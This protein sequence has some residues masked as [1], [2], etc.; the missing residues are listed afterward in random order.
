[1]DKMHCIM[2]L[3]M[4]KCKKTIIMWLVGNPTIFQSHW[5]SLVQLN[6]IRAVQGHCEMVYLHT[7]KGSTINFHITWTMHKSYVTLQWLHNERDGV[8]NHQRLYCLLKCWL[9]HKSKKTIWKLH[10]TG[11]C[12]GNP[13][14]TSGFPSQ[15][16]S[17]MEICFHL[18][19]SSWIWGQHCSCQCSYSE[20]CIAPNLAK[21]S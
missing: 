5:K 11:L 12:E 20:A 21:N 13:L 1:M 10:V 16:A 18:M 4:G 7:E 2:G 19:T 3:S 15:R 14:V 6:G 9:R 17:N 8:S